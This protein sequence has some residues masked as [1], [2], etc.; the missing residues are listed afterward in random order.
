L[1]PKVCWSG[2]FF[3]G[4]SL[5]FVNR[6]LVQRLIERDNLEISI[7][8]EPVRVDL[9][10]PDYRHF[11]ARAT[12]GIGKPDITVVTG[13]IPLT[14]GVPTGSR[15]IRYLPWEYGA[16][17]EI[18]YDY[19]HEECDDLWA[20]STYN[21]DAYVAG[22]F[23][24]ERIAAIPHGIDPRIFNA[25]PRSRSED[26]PFRFLYVGATIP[27]KGIDLMVNAY[28][29]TFAPG[30]NVILTIKDVNPDTFYR[31]TSKGSEIRHFANVPTLA[32]MEYVDAVIRDED[33]A[34]LYRNAD[35]LVLP[36]R[37]EGFAMPVLEAMA[38]GT[39]V[40]ATAGGATDDFVDEAVGWRIPSTRVDT[41]PGEPVPTRGRAWLME[42]DLDAL[43]QLLRHAYEHRGETRMRGQAG[44]RRAA[45]W[46]WD[47]AAR[48][49]EE[50]LLEIAARPV[51][52]SASRDARYRNARVYED[53]R[54]GPSL[55]DGVLRE[56]FARMTVTDPHYLEINPNGKAVLTAV[57][58]AFQWNGV[59]LAPSDPETLT[60]QISAHGI[61]EGFDVLA[62]GCED[63]AS[64]WE[65]LATLRP[66]A[67]ASSGVLR[68]ALEP[69]AT[70]LGYA[71]I[72][73]E[74]QDGD[75]IFLRSDLLGAAAFDVLG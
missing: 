25:A 43:S 74:Q 22:G 33:M 71:R 60:L 63:A 12:A 17:P 40:M 42:C 11:A 57:L 26:E 3:S 35:C 10:E 48:I 37:G 27:R 53:R 24:R 73:T 8:T 67:V 69:I 45:Q 61:R 72:A 2:D 1:R 20:P 39:A 62:L 36:Y 38:C 14:H 31:G 65:T 47:R 23:P 49:T 13:L 56:L 64:T 5:A 59:V 16:M 34:Y 44:A 55:L 54:S 75:S 30:D 6:R 29:R 4:F 51:V 66:R 52:P 68:S 32:R 21:A 50:R 41:P 7:R 46:T 28:F 9:V 19:L 18:W 15:Y 58:A 70:Q